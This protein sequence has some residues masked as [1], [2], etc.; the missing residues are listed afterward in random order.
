MAK[1]ILLLVILFSVL[2]PVALCT[3]P[4]PR[5][6]LRT[7]QILTFGVVLL[8]GYLCLTYYPQ[9]VAVD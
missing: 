5:R 7:I 9:L 4:S 2:V 1:L 6:V 3:R 8:W